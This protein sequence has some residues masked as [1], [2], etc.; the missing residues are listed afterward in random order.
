MNPTKEQNAKI[1]KRA[2]I[3]AT[4]GPATDNLEMIERMVRAGVNC[5]RLNCSHGT[6]DEREHQI[7]WI[8]EAASKAGKPVAI[9]QD[10][11][12][13]KIRLGEM[14]GEV[15][16][17]VGESWRL[18]FSEAT[19]ETAK[20]L[21]VQYDLSQKVKPHEPIFLFDGKVQAIITAVDPAT[22]SITI[23]IK[24]DGVV[25]KRKGINLP[26]TDFG[27]DILTEKDL[28][29]LAWGADK[30]IDYVAFSFVQTSED[31]DHLKTLLKE[32]GSRAN[33]I[34]KIETKLAIEPANLDAIVRASDGVMVARGDLAVEAGAEV[35]PIVQRD[36]IGKSQKYGK[37]SIVATQMMASMV[38]ATSPTRAEVSDVAHA[39]IT[40]ADCVMLSDETAVGKW[41]IETIQAMKRV[42]LYTQEHAPVRPIY[43]REEITGKQDAISSAA[44]TLAQQIGADAIVAETKSGAT[45]KSI[46]SHRPSMPIISV[47][48]DPRVAQQL[49]MLY[50]NKSFL[51]PD[52]ERAGLELAQ[53][54][55][56][57]GFL[58]EK[59][60]VVLVSGHQP[61]VVGMTDTIRV[62]IIE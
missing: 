17:K 51:R 61:G 32:H 42:I 54:L 16:L 21:S 14:E 39:V 23:Y 11:Q 60:L 56:D 48:S 50:A 36:I 10:L 34:S 7:A 41:P 44:V 58:P 62:R 19:D 35:V 3:V 31:V 15:R 2:K 30:D 37:L 43:F 45:A 49:A 4:V 46:A 53:Q 38:E 57:D 29:D 40:G 22:H 9:M 33:V 59:A 20:R 27:G 47:T 1:Y 12:G 28:A 52:G 18:S 24:N 5:F 25:M 13:P 26:E 55:R 6:N 8:R